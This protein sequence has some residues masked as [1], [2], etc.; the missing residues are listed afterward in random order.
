[1]DGEGDAAWD[2][3]AM[4]RE[5]RTSGHPAGGPLGANRLGPGVELGGYRLERL[6]GRG[7]VGAVY[8]AVDR[9][10]DTPVALKTLDLAREF[11]GIDFDAA[12]ERFL[13]EAQA[14]S[15]LNHP[16]IVTVYGAGEERGLAYIA[17][18]PLTG[19]DLTRYTR[20]ARLLPEP[21]VLRIVA[22]VAEAL[23]SAHAQG[24][25]HRDVKPA[26]V[27]V[28]LA[29]HQVKL[30]DFGI[31]RLTD[32]ERTRTGLLI[33][34]PSFMSPEQLAGSRLDGRSD[35][36]SLGVMLFQLLTGRLPYDGHSMGE[37]LRAIA[38][39]EPLDLRAVRSDLPD[40][41]A[42]VVATAL[43]KPAAERFADGVSF[44]S[45]IRRAELDLVSH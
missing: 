40:S 35:L 16:D 22:R 41:L 20:S 3:D 5:R 23:A 12:R 37:L 8:L 44:A 24:V 42:H 11:E 9:V 17:M 15:R 14:A 45:A 21:V 7:A 18:E 43:R 29:A 32:G 2:A 4:D 34:T 19:S 10:N 25:L 13:R 30:T 1:M 28:D 31:A 36:Y 39:E 27:M 26:N 38:S 33:G 6:I